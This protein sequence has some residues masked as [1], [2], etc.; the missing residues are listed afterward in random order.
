M[1]GMAILT[2]LW[3]QNGSYPARS[4]RQLVSA[5]FG[6][7]ER[8]LSGLVVSQNGAG[9]LS[10]NI[11]EGACVVQGDDQPDQGMYLVVVDD[12]YNQAMP[13]APGSNKRID[14]VTI[15]VNDPQAGGSAGNNATVVIV[16]GG[17]AAFPSAPA[18]PSSSIVL[19][20]VLRTVGDGSVLTSMIT[21]VGPR[22]MFPYTVSTSNPS[23][24][25]VVGDLWVKYQ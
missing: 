8:L 1:A 20:Q 5:V 2:P 23:G 19:A 6:G 11:S 4:D 10:V 3:M 15:K 7:R 24:V 25:G 14:L 22:G 12:V 17:V 21:D 9:D 18:V 16:Q 13:A